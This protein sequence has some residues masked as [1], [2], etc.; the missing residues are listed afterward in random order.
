MHTVF[1]DFWTSFTPAIVALIT[2][3][4]HNF[5]MHSAKLFPTQAKC[6]YHNFG[7][8]GSPQNHDALCFLPQNTVNEKIFVFFYFWFIMVSII[9]VIS[10]LF[11]ASMMFSKYLRK[12]H[13]HI[14]CNSVFTYRYNDFYSRFSHCGLW[15]SL[16]LIHKNLGPILFQDLLDDLI[17]PEKA[18]MK[19]IGDGDKKAEAT[20][21][22]A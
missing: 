7:P 22:L 3:D 21:V 19:L 11:L 4:Y 18:K 14:M 12:R 1:N 15:F 20:Q 9:Q 17:N 16:R 6:L 13:L 8:S 10:C 2:E 5:T